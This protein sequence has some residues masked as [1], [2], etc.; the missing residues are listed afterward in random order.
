MM[1]QDLSGCGFVVADFESLGCRIYVWIRSKLS[2]N[3]A[4]ITTVEGDAE[5]GVSQ[6]RVYN[7]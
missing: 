7:G 5:L 6:M 1:S 4:E 3:A 2:V